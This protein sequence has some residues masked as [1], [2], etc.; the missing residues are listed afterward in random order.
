MLSEGCEIA[1]ENE[2]TGTFFLRQDDS[3]GEEEEQ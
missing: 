3:N 2:V 1:C